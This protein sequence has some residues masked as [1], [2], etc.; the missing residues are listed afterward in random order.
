MILDHLGIDPIRFSVEW[1]SA[2]EGIRFAQVITEFDN[3]IKDLGELGKKEA[4]D[5]QEL[6][7]KLRAAWK[8]AESRML[9]TPFAIQAKQMKKDDTYGQ[10]P[11][12]EKLLGTFVREMTLYQTLLY[13][14]EKERSASELAELLDIPVDQVMSF[15]ETLKKKNMWNGELCRA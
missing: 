2:A 8:A 12:R 14:E 13:L 10:F 15:V 7:Y 9:R 4:L 1:V 6:K 11:S 5:L 3:K